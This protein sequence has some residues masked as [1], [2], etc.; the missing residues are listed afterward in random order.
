MKAINTVILMFAV[1]VLSACQHT[2]QKP[3][4]LLIQAREVD[5][6]FSQWPNTD[7]GCSVGVLHN[8]EFVLNKGYGIADLEQGTYNN[9]D[10]SQF[11][12]A[13]MTKQLTAATIALMDEQFDHFSINDK[14]SKYFPQ[15]IA[16][17]ENPTDADQMTIKDLIYHT[18]GIRNYLELA[19]LSRSNF[20]FTKTASLEM[21]KRQK[22]LNF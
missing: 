5:K 10:K 3:T 11:R 4:P 19:I 6:I 14:V 22:H 9:T 1:V 17:I 15:L 2:A 18:S 7:P 20:N 13:S 16:N 12:I 21:I 8:G